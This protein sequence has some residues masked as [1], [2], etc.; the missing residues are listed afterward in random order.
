[1]MERKKDAISLE[2][3]TKDSLSESRNV[4]ESHVTVECNGLEDLQRFNDVCKDIGIKAIQIQLSKGQYP[5]HLMTASWHKGSFEEVKEEVYGIGYVLQEKGCVPLRHKIEAMLTNIQVPKTDYDAQSRSREQ[6]FEFHVKVSKEI[7][8]DSDSLQQLCDRHDAHLSRSA[9]NR[10]E[11]IEQ[12]FVT[13]RYRVGLDN[14]I[15]LYDDLLLDLE[16]SGFVLSKKIKEYTVHDDNLQY[17]VGWAYEA[18]CESC[19]EDSCPFE[20]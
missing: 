9:A 11:N 10:S 4:Y 2:V 7:D 6:Y 12:R 17:D 15:S 16:K 1:M 19:G 20:E 3:I 5:T 18:P 8:K 13:V 14:A